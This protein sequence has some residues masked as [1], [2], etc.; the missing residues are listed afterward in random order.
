[1]TLKAAALPQLSPSCSSYT[2]CKRLSICSW[3]VLQQLTQ[4]QMAVRTAAA[5][6]LR[7]P[8]R[9]PGLGCLLTGGLKCHAGWQHST[10]GGPHSVKGCTHTMQHIATTVMHTI[11]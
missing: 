4:H 9:R 3:R 1:V 6:C 7:L 10:A 2:A 8:V 5:W 11:D